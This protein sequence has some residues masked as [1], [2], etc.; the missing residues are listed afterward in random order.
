MS[1]TDGR[2]LPALDTFP[3]L[4]LTLTA[5]SGELP[6]ALISRL[7]ASDS[8]K[9]YTVKRLKQDNLLRTY[10][11][12]GVRG[13]RLTA[14]AKKLLLAGWPDQ[15]SPYLS[16]STETNQLKSEITRRLRL[17]RMAEV[18]VTMYNA[19]ALMFPWEKPPIFQPDPPPADICIPQPLYYSSREVKELGQQAIKVRNSRS[20]GVLLT[21]GGIFIVYNIGPYQIKWEYKAEIRLK[22]LLFWEL[23]QVRLPEIFMGVEQSVIVFGADMNRLDTLMGV[24]GESSHNYFVLDGGFNHV[25]FLNNDHKGETLLRLLCDLDLR[26]SLDTVLSENLRPPDPDLPM[27]NDGLDGDM[28]VLFGYT[29]DMPRIRRFDSALGIQKESGLLICFDFQAEALRR[30]CSPRVQ[31]QCLD[32]E[33]CERRVFQSQGNS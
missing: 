8:Y 6:A 20:T 15:F 29:C 4:V 25:Y 32:F 19:G 27:E 9:E 5:L 2:E 10:Y 12:N 3:G 30:C 13:L 21:D 11:R 14:A 24:S 16:G 1:G 26:E 23:C 31:F 17:H 28:P 18:L 22:G 7:P 33:E